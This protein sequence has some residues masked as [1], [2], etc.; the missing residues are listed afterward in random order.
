MKKVL[1]TLIAYSLLLT[2]NAQIITTVAGNGTGGFSGNGGQATAAELNQPYGVL[3]DASGN[4]YIGDFSNNV[5]RMVNTAGIISDFAGNHIAGFSGDGGQATAAQV[6]LPAGISRDG[7]GNIYIADASNE[8]IRKVNT[9]GIISTIAGNGTM[10]YSG[11]GGPATA[12]ELKE[13]FGTAIDAAGNVYIADYQNS[14]IRIVN[15][16]GIIETFAGNG[17]SGYSGDG[18]QATAAAINQSTGV[19]LDG[20]GNLF[21]ADYLN[22][23]VRMVNTSGIITTFAGNGT[24]GYSGDGGQA[25]AAEINQATG[26]IVDVSGNLYLQEWS[27]FRIR[28][29]S[30]SGVITTLAGDGNGGYSG[31]GGP[32]TAA[33]IN[34]SC[35]LSFD[36]SGNLY[37]ADELN[38]RIRK[39]TGIPLG[40]N[41]AVN[42]NEF[43]V[44]PN[45]S[46]GQFQIVIAG[47]AKQSLALVDVYNMLGEKVYS[48]EL[49]ITNY[50]LLIHM[51]NQPAGIYLLKLQTEDG[52]ILTKKIEVTR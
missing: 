2:A 47:E 38:Y 40:V 41:Q 21:I 29:V 36:G 34:R 9:S 5:V 50:Q 51:N 8:R 1:L 7:A 28:K 22:N 39:I 14:R 49:L 48:N 42:T 6:S 3:C 13:P 32:A 45:P 4:F 24:A 43:A 20:A 35:G 52:S 37:I 16:S 17:V 30:A 31:D 18:G 33:E 46:N 25:T 10:G 12:A 19:A 26:V 15:T 44:Y 27:G 23:R 11:D